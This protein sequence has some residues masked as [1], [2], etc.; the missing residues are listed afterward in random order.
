VLAQR[1]AYCDLAVAW[2]QRADLTAARRADELVDLL[3]ADA[4]ATTSVAR[5]AVGER[6]FDVGSGVWVRR[7]FRSR[8]CPTRSVWV[9]LAKASLLELQ[10]RRI[11]ADLSYSWPLTGAERRAV[12]VTAESLARAAKS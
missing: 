12:C 9:L 4:S 3:L 2:N 6:W 10:G 11:L 1:C 7:A 5:V 8:S